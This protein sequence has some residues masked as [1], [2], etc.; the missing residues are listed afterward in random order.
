MYPK[1]VPRY[2]LACFE[3]VPSAKQRRGLLLSISK[4]PSKKLAVT[5]DMV[6]R[7]V[8]NGKFLGHSLQDGHFFDIF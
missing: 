6:H 2:P 5:Y 7:A 1:N 3:L 8:C 4:A